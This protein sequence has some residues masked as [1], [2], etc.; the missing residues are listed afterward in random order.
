MYYRVYYI[1][2][3][4][5]TLCPRCIPD[6]CQDPIPFLGVFII[7]AVGVQVLFESTGLTVGPNIECSNSSG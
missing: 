5:Y 2:T 3:C 6:F 7:Q 1:C 4:V